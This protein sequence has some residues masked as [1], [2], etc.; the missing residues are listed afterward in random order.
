MA[1]RISP[2]NCGKP[3]RTGS[4]FHHSL[5]NNP[6]PNYI[7]LY[8]QV[9]ENKIFTPLSKAPETFHQP[10]ANNHLLPKGLQFPKKAYLCAAKMIS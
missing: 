6:L 2:I 7:Q 4:P 9:I 8:I 5:K 10:S 1:V 3:L